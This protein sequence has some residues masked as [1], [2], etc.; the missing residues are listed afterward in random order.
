MAHTIE[1]E[2]GIIDAYGILPEIPGTI[3]IVAEI[4]VQENRYGGRFYIIDKVP[5]IESVEFSAN[6]GIGS[7]EASRAFEKFLG[8][9]YDTDEAFKARINE[10]ILKDMREA[11]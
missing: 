10:M 3:E 1:L 6:L 9:L 8:T 11:A 4:D 2:T 5:Y 7:P